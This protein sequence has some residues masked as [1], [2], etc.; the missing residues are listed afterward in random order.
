MAG[1]PRWLPQRSASHERAARA[2]GCSDGVRSRTVWFVALVRPQ[3]CGCA[4]CDS[5][6]VPELVTLT[7]LTDEWG[8]AGGLVDMLARGRTAWTRDAARRGATANARWFPGRG[9]PLR[10]AQALCG[11]RPPR[12]PS[13]HG[14]STNAAARRDLGRHDPAAAVADPGQ[15]RPVAEEPDLHSVHGSDMAVP[16]RRLRRRQLEA[17]GARSARPGVWIYRLRNAPAVW[18]PGMGTSL[19]ATPGS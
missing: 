2:A 11:G 6:P 19:G 13:W 16:H 14:R 3:Q 12:P 15:A 9:D 4:R 8:E 1:C 5:A 17:V 7:I 10:P 18:R